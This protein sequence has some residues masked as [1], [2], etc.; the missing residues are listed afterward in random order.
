MRAH[1]LTPVAG[2]GIIACHMAGTTTKRRSLFGEILR[3]ELE[4]QGVSTRE[5]ARRLAADEGSAENTRRTLIRYLQ[6]EVVPG[7]IM[8]EAIAEALSIDPTVFDEGAERDARRERVLDALAPL[9]DVLLDIVTEIR[10]E[11]DR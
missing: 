6:G 9:A 4:Q 7:Q 11:Q 5:L 3:G 8:R 10:E 2:G 1:L